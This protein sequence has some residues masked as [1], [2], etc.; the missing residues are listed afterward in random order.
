MVGR[1]LG[2]YRILEKIGAGGM[3]EVYRAHDERLDRDV[4]V[5]VLPPSSFADPTAHARLLR[6]A[7]TA[8]KLNHPHICTIHEVGEADGQA[9]I[10]M[11]YVEG[12]PLS[13][14]VAEQTL[15]V[16]RVLRYG[17]Q[18]AD[19]LAHAHEHG[20]VHRDL[21][22]ANVVIT[23]EGRAKVL[24]FGL[25][26][27]LREEELETVTRSQ[28]SLTAEGV[29]MGTLAYMAPEQLRGQPAD[30]RSDVWALG[31]MLHEMLA[32]QRPFRGNTGYELSS[33]ILMKSPE[34]LPAKVPPEVRAVIGRCLA[35]EPGERYQRAAEVRAAL[36]A[37]AT[38]AVAPW[39][40]LRYALRRRQ[41]LAMSAAVVLL[42]AAAVVMNLGGLRERLFGTAPV[43]IDSI[44]VLPLANLSGDPEQEY[45]SDGMTE[46]LIIDL[47]KLSGLR[48]VIARTSVMQ[49]KGSEKPLAEIARELNVDAVLTGSVLRVGD[50]VRI[51][52][53]LIN[54]RTEEHLWADRYER[55]LRDVLTLQ[56]E[57]VTTIARQIEVTLT[58]AEATRLAEARPVNPEAYEAFVKGRHH[59]NKATP[60]EI[61]KAIA[62]FN[63]AIGKDPDYALPYAGLADSYN[64]L[65]FVG[66]L[67]PRELFPRAK[68]AAARALEIDD[69]L[70][71]AHSA[72]GYAAML[73]D[74]DWAAAEREHQ[75]AV[76][77]NPNSA[78]AHLQYSWYLGSQGRFEQA[79][80]AIIRASELDPL[81]L[82]I[83]ANMSNYFHWKRDYD[84]MLEQTRKTLE[85]DPNHSLGHLFSGHAYV[86]K[87]LYDDAIAEYEKA[88]EVSGGGPGFKG[89]LGYAYALAGHK[90][91]AL[92]ILHE[93]KELSKKQ[94][95]PS[96]GIAL[97][98]IGLEDTDQAFAWLEKAY[99]ERDVL[100]LYLTMAR[101]FDPLRDDPR[102]QDLLR[103][104]NLPEK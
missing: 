43:K 49:Y 13:R 24:D 35:K 82:I 59:L 28:A 95:V 79:R 102:F 62:Y 42:V 21:K 18:I 47:A 52:A 98:L 14:L 45:F 90:G 2:H 4:A 68:R 77:L 27:Q 29:V 41:L 26:K 38:G 8:S 91:K 17:Q 15:P 56:N 66:G 104:L 40:G 33:A 34:P 78:Q 83:S 96:V 101:W 94:Y 86:G 67:A 6:E 99:E 69:S 60:G 65:A 25:A 81:S 23:P 88:V 5:K 54:A 61:N 92:E 3:G 72:L 63:E 73:Y 31:V 44:A 58:P 53:Q 11:E 16:E 57:I 74:W 71:E 87:G 12:R 32:G 93:L 37:I 1:T 85:L 10:A 55:E 76:E 36:E 22:S 50:R 39:V 19:G 51:T 20:I 97:V 9:Y 100:F 30:A 64:Y 7:R 89:H 48:R 103:R 70:A 84:G 75:R 46:A 80:A